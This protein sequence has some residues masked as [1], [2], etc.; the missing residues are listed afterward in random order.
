MSAA[1][2]PDCSSQDETAPMHTAVSKA[3]QVIHHR[4][5][6][7]VIS[8]GA[9]SHE[10]VRHPYLA[11]GE[12]RQGREGRLDG[13]VHP[14][15]GPHRAG[16]HRGRRVPEEPGQQQVQRRGEQAQQLRLL[17]FL[18]SE[19][20]PSAGA[21]RDQVPERPRRHLS[22]GE[23]TV[24]LRRTSKLDR[25]GKTMNLF[26]LRTWLEA[27]FTATERGASMVEYILL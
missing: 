14:P 11:R 10:P 24:R 1:F 7:S 21:F 15:R 27:R 6:G 3:V 19:K 12:V 16:R 4:A 5:C 26:V 13:G 20:T 8:E 25:R 23:S 18:S 9:R 2:R 17:T 22:W